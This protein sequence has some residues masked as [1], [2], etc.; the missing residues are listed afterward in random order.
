MSPL[1]KTLQEVRKP[2]ALVTALCD[3]VILDGKSNRANALDKLPS[4]LHVLQ[5]RVELALEA[6]AQ[7]REGTP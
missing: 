1:L 4:A 3:S 7:E 6:L 5:L 2:A